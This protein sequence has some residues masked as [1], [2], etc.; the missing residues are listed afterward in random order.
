M[1]EELAV[2]GLVSAIVQF[3]EFG[4]KVEARLNEF[5]S[6]TKEVP[7]A[8]SD[9]RQELPLI[10]E[11]LEL[12]QK[13]A[14]VG[15][16]NNKTATSLKTF[17]DGCLEKIKLLKVILDKTTPSEQS[18]T[19]QKRLHA[20]KSLA[21]DRDVQQ[22]TSVLQRR[23]QESTLYQATTILDLNSSLRVDLENKYISREKPVFMVPFERHY[24]FIGRAEILE[25]LELKLNKKNRRVALAGIGGVE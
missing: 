21:R 16:F 15:Y 10:I 7:K 22:I 25:E 14:D 12:I 5:G 2:V 24:D 20:I 9:L 18:S 17:V 8:L 4:T 1:A 19:W 11:T 13:R 6:D 23:L 3:V